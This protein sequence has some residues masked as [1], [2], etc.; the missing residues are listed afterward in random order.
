MT[1][2][3]SILIG[4]VI[5][6]FASV[7]ILLVTHEGRVAIR[8]AMLVPEVMPNPGF[9]P[10]LAISE[11][12]IEQ[13]LKFDYTGG[14]ANGTLYRPAGPGQHGAVILFLGINPNYDQETL[15]Q[16]ARAVA[17]QGAVVLLAHGVALDRGSVSTED[18]DVLVGGIR[19]LK[20]QPYVNEKRIGIAGFCLGGSIALLA[21]GDPRIAPDVRFV[22]SF[23][24]FYSPESLIKALTTHTVVVDS[25]KQEPWQPSNSAYQWFVQAVFNAL[26]PGERDDLR[27]LNGNGLNLSPQ[28]RAA[29]PTRERAIYNLLANRDPQVF[30]ELYDELPADL[31]TAMAK[32][33][34]LSNLP[35]LQAKVFLMADLNDEYVPATESKDL[36]VALQT[37]PRRTYTEFQL[38]DHMTPT[39]KLEGLPLARELV[40]LFYHLYA[41]LL[42][43]S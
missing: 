39:T 35:W 40:K 20:T 33:A 24:G 15:Q 21:A 16:F 26:P 19:F 30:G 22:N 31:R 37:Y 7:A 29:L 1:L 4:I 27:R 43:M 13:D 25:L 11:A 3:R 6:L 17:R 5:L 41:V 34:P 36:N 8:A 23:G 38:F 10:L 9:R 12:P 32:L 28:E 42:E 2:L 14:K 18:V